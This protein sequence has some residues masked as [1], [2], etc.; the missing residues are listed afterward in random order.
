MRI[1]YPVRDLTREF[2]DKPKSGTLV[3]DIDTSRIAK[4]LGAKAAFNKGK[5]ARSLSGA[6]IVKFIAE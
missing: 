3:M 1:T 6:I 4:Q 5:K 2:G